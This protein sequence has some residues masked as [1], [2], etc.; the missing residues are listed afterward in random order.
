MQRYN[1]QYGLKVFLSNFLFSH[2]QLKHLGDTGGISSRRL[3]FYLGIFLSESPDFKCRRARLQYSLRIFHRIF[4]TLSVLRRRFQRTSR[5]ISQRVS[6]YIRQSNFPKAAEVF[7]VPS[8]PNIVFA[9]YGNYD[10]S[11]RASLHV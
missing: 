11:N 5:C 3:H 8:K 7:E 1:G 10:S 2:S 6:I 9:V 4:K